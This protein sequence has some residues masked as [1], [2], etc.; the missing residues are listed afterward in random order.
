MTKVAL[1]IGAGRKFGVGASTARLFARNGYNIAL[2]FSKSSE[3]AESIVKDCLEY[4]VKAELFQGDMSDTAK[5]KEMTDSVSSKFG[6]I[7]SVIYSAGITK[8]A[9]YD[10]LNALSLDDFNRIFMINCFSAYFVASSVKEAL[11]ASR[12]SFTAISST[13]GITGM[14]SSIAYAASKGALNT[15][16][17]SLAKALAPHVRVNA[18]APSFI[19]SSWWDERFQGKKEKY[20]AFKADMAAK[21]ALGEVLMPDDVARCAF[22]LAENKVTGE[23]L[24]LDAGAHVK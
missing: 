13:A 3:G 19:D 16:V 2:N 22:Y 14:G 18:I 23:I 10:D 5:I 1:L 11:I 17:L 4:G 21:T 24:R 15:L 8:F 12:G 20:D 6:R 7:D 9:S